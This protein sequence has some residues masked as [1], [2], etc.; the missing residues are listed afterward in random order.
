M[1]DDSTTTT[2]TRTDVSLAGAHKALAAATATAERLGVA[3][4]AVVCDRGGHPVASLRMDGAPVLSMD[5]A[6][7][8]A[9]TVT[10]FNGVPTKAWWPMIEHEPALVH[11]ITHT[12]RLVV[13]GGGEPIQVRGDLAGAIGVSGGS[14]EQDA[15]IAMAG[16]AALQ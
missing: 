10:M 15:E 16:A 12:P 14:A 2:T 8:K 1:S 11:G 9:W 7:N 5:I 4:C 6:T 3:I 13:F